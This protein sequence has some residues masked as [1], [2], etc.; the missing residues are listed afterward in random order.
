MK[1][2]I[3]LFVLTAFIAAC[4]SEPHYVV[5]GNIEGSDS[6]TFL[7]QK[8]EA[9]KI[10]T[11]DSALSEKGTFKMTG[12]VEYPALVYLIA[13]KTR[14]RL[15]FYLENSAI[16]VTGELDSLDVA[17]VTGSK[18]Q[19]EYKSFLGSNKPLN[20]K[21]MGLYKEYQT[22]REANN[23]TKI[24]QVEEDAERI[25]LEMIKL[26][27][28]FVTNNPAS[29]I[30]PDLIRG[31]TLEMEAAELETVISAL[32]T[33]VAKVPVIT[34]LMERVRILKSVAVGQK[35]PD[36]TLNDVKGNPVALSSKTGSKLLLIDFWAAW[37]NPC[38]QENPNVVKVYNQFRK[39]GFDVFSVSLDR[40][41]DAW[42]KAI[43]DDK[44]TWTHVSDLQYWN[45]AAARLYGVGS[46]PANFLLDETGTIIA[47]NLRGE[48]LFNKVNEILS[49]K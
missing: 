26:Q 31:L 49:K 2:V 18:T 44:L 1:K 10:I 14:N 46:I 13:L 25:R 28:E 34:E 12:A 39:K 22:A 38:R 24:A 7:L 6:I 4:S 21:M 15:G 17:T 29:Y 8:R 42:I 36:F 30:T 19:D 32:D 41:K 3:Y 47:K 20:D 33:N 23:E 35:A 48:D 37:C 9:G 40:S 11:L 5:K 43:A 27:K 45:N 16:N